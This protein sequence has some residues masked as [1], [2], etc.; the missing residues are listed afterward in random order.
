MTPRWWTFG[1][2][3][4]L[5]PTVNGTTWPMHEPHEPLTSNQAPDQVWQRALSALN[6][7][8]VALAV[9]W[10]ARDE[11]DAELRGAAACTVLCRGSGQQARHRRVTGL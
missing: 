11:S 10:L 9:C 3:T 8:D 6:D 7:G 5:G 2:P 1:Q 4:I